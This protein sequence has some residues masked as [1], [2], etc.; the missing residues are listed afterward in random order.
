MLRGHSQ[1]KKQQLEQ[2]LPMLTGV[3]FSS[4]TCSSRILILL[5]SGASQSIINQK[6][7]D[8]QTLIPH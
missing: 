7:I 2:A 6:V 4:P 1:S 3:V 5:D 8:K